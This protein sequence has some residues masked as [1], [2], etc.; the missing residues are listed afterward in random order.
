MQL[1]LRN[2]SFAI[3][4]TMLAALST[5]SES[6]NKELSV[7]KDATVS[8]TNRFGKIDV[9]AIAPNADST[10]TKGEITANSD[11]TILEKEVAISVKGSRID[12][13]VRPS[14]PKT[15]IDLK[16][17]LPERTSVSVETNDGAVMVT[18]D[19]ALIDVTTVTGTVA[20]DVPTD[21]VKY[22]L[23]WTQS[24]PRF[25]SDIELKK[26][27]EKAGGKF[28]I[29]G[30]TTDPG[31]K[32]KLDDPV[33]EDPGTA[34]TADPP[35]D[36]ARQKE[37]KKKKKVSEGVTLRLTT[38]R[39]IYLLNVPP[40][41]VSS[42]LRERPLTNAAKAII[43]SGDSFLMDAIRRASPKYFG[44]YMK[45][46]PPFKREPSFSAK[47]Q[48]IDVPVAKVKVALVRVIDSDNRTVSGLE[49]K[50]FEVSENNAD[51]EVV[52]VDPAT[53]PVNLV[54]LL[55]VS[56]SIENYVNFIRKAARSFV[57]TVGRND[58]ISIVIFND[59]VK[60]L[61]GF[62]TDRQELSTS[63]DTFDAGGGTAYYDALAY[64]L[65]DTLRPLKGERTAVVVLTDGDD[66]RSFLAF[67]SLAG[68][69]QES[70]ALIYPLYVPSGLIAASAG[71]NPDNT[72][73]PLRTKYMGLTTKA[74]GEGEKLAKISGGSYYPITQLSQ[75][76]TAYDDIVQQ[77]RTAYV[78]TYRGSSDATGNAGRS[79]KL[80]IRAKRDGTTV[81]ITSVTAVN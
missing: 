76:Q 4:Y 58:R 12:I 74:E 31:A 73:D 3:I 69:I 48:G 44:D 77:L 64:T 52:S 22:D 20:V 10:T 9:E 37:S 72:V 46:L 70:G 34:D 61:S 18:G 50:D 32:K 51:R 16:L 66:N 78:I 45:T 23:L 71:S 8:V 27:K 59:D 28:V 17:T 81:N 62:T 14:D 53:A 79:P 15:R 24:R 21:D 35:A 19:L 54:L 2:L 29:R 68:S 55:D 49:V 40:N 67:D 33:A 25:L 57:D 47:A 38:V 6:F 42:D 11:K 75:I 13:E 60:V 30:E 39:G 80:K 65:A 5:F 1:H 7:P 36:Q 41:E 26:V 56:G 63:L 43:R